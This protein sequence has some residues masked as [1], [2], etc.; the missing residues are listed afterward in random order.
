MGEG[1]GVG[2]GVGVGV[3]PPELQATGRPQGSPLPGGPLF[4]GSVGFWFWLKNAAVKLLLPTLAT[5]P[6]WYVCVALQGAAQVPP[7]GV[8]VGDG[9]G[10]GLG[11][12]DGVGLGVGEGVGVGVGVGVGEPVD[13]GPIS[14]HSAGTLGGS[15]PTWEVWA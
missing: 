14:F 8:G 7:E 10:D 6:P 1:F 12:G 3:G 2:D 11:V 13:A 4:P 9:V 5:S 15:H